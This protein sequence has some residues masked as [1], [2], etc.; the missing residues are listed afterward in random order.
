LSRLNIAKHKKCALKRRKTLLRK[1]AITPQGMLF[2]QKVVSVSKLMR[3]RF[4][5]KSKKDWAQW[6]MPV[7]LAT[8]EAEIRGSQ[9]KKLIRP[10]FNNKTGV[11][12]HVCN[13]DDV[14]VLAGGIMVRG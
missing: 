5:K 4:L 8:W 9:A 13:T 14:G 3:K 6:L 2:S 10:C 7:V 12:A 11:T 1:E